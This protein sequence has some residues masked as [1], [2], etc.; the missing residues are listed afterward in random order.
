MPP[1]GYTPDMSTDEAGMWMQVDKLEKDIQ[2]SPARIRDE[3]LNA[4]VQGLVCKL[5]GEYCG[6]IRLYVMEVPAF[7]AETLPNGAMVVW[8]GLLLRS[9]NEAQLAFVLG[10]EITHYLHR[11]SLERMRRIVSTSG[12]MAVFGIVTAGAGVGLI[13]LAANAAAVGAL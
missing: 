4:Y 3:K 5:A 9:E 12:F 8:S 13:G 10:H 1:P 6:S 2:S 11:H 7:N